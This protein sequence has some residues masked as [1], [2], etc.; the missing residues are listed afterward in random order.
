MS[1]CFT[2]LLLT[3]ALWANNSVLV[4][5]QKASSS[6]GFYSPAGKHLGSASVGPHPHEM[7][8]S[9][10]GRY[11]YTTDNGTMRIEQPGAGGNTVSIVDVM[12][13]AKVGEISLGRFRRPHGIDINRG[14]GQ[15]AV[16]TE[17]PDQL[18][19]IDPTARKVVRNFET[20]G[21]T[22]H[23][24][25]LGPGGRYAYVSNSSSRNISAIDLSTG[26]VTLIT[27]GDRPEG[28]ALSKDGRELYVGN[29]DGQTISIID[30]AKN[31][32]IGEIP[33][34]KG[35]VRMARTPD[36]SALVFALYHENKIEIA[37]PKARKVVARVNLPE[38]VVSL[39][40]SRDGKLAFASAEDKD[41]VFVVSLADRTIVRQISTTPGA[42][43]DPVMEIAAE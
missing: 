15:L 27:T 41:T 14:T 28:A 18:L 31:S 1:R 23:M 35:S 8:L 39:N 24:V 42:G 3:T 20:K 36:G 17:L 40:L 22:S 25:S 16:T 33:I 13:R 12:A 38:H 30:T 11:L 2:F 29:R 10:D 6:A 5:L 32:V 4:I 9:N 7:V 43:P 34:G 37:D 19:L 21:K 26:E